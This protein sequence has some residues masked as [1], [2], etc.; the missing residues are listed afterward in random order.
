MKSL[1]EW[2]GA[3]TEKAEAIYEESHSDMMEEII[4]SVTLTADHNTYELHDMEIEVFAQNERNVVVLRSPTGTCKTE[5]AKAL[6]EREAKKGRK[7]A[8]LTGLIAVVKQH[9][10]SNVASAFY[11]EQMHVIENATH[12]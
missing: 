7:T 4:K 6:I 1:I 11:D 8:T 2:T 5:F 9:T 3:G 12:L 10:P